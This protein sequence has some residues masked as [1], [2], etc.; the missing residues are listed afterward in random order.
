MSKGKSA[1]VYQFDPNR[2]RKL[3]SVNYVSPE[4]KNLLRDRKKSEKN[5]KNFYIGLVVL[6]LAVVALTLIKLR[7]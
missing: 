7:F 1:S 3:K 5:R 6:L 4:K 2:K